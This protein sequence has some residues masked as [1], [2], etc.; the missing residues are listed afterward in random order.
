MVAHFRWD[1]RQIFRMA[2]M[3]GHILRNPAELLFI[4]REA[5][6]TVHTA[7]TREEVQKCLSVLEQ[8]ERLIVKFAILAGLRPGEII[9]T[10]K[11]K[12]KPR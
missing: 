6:L 4:L 12:Q 5:A 10:S 2:V 1:L 8:R 9:W 11:E 7:M 3:E